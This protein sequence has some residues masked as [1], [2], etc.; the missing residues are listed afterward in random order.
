MRIRNWLF[1]SPRWGKRTSPT[2][3]DGQSRTRPVNSQAVSSRKGACQQLL[4]PAQ[5]AQRGTPAPDGGG[6]GP[7][8]KTRQ[9]HQLKTK[10][11]RKKPKRGEQQRVVL[12]IHEVFCELY[13]RARL[14]WVLTKR[15]VMAMRQLRDAVLMQLAELGRSKLAQA[16]LMGY[17]LGSQVSVVKLYPMMDAFDD[18]RIA[19][20]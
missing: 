6:S 9:L 20:C 15:H 1:S 8:V 11:R 12:G 2:H 14:D 10:G 16:R 19:K 5:A 17:C 4:L 13:S 18:D 7:A 3:E